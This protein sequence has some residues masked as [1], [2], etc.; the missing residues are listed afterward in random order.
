MCFE[1]ASSVLRARL[2]DLDQLTE[3]IAIFHL[4]E[5]RTMTTM[6]NMMAGD[7]SCYD[8]DSKDRND[9]VIK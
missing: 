5:M 1:C 9:D 4:S 7:D 3:L 6:M 8:D 2:K